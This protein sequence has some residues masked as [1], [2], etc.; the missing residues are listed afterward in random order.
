[1]F[2][3]GVLNKASVARAEP[4]YEYMGNKYN[5]IIHLAGASP[6]G[7]SGGS[8]VN[9]AGQVIGVQSGNMTINSA[10]QGVSMMAPLAA[11]KVLMKARRH[12]NT[13]TLNSGLEE[14]WAQEVGFIR[15]FQGNHGLI[16]RQLK[17]GGA[18]ARAGVEE[19]HVITELDGRPLAFLAD[20]LDAIRKKEP[21]D[22]VLLQV[23]DRVGLNARETEVTLGALEARWRAPKKPHVIVVLT[24]DMGIGDLGVMGN[25]AIR[26]PNIDALAARAAQM[27]NFFVHPVCAPTR[28]CTMT[29]RY[30]YRTRVVDTWRGRAMM[31]PSEKTIAE[32]LRDAGYATGIFGKWHLGDAYPMRAMDQGFDESLVCWG[33]GLA[34]PAEPPENARRY[35]NPLLSHNGETVP[36]EGY[37]T[38]VF[39]DRAIA[40]M[41]RT[42]LSGKSCFTYLPTNAPHGPFH[43]VPD[44]LYRAY[45][46]RGLDD[47][48]ARIYAM[49]ENIDQ[50]MGKLD[51]FLEQ[52]G[53]K[54]DTLLI[55]FHDNGPNGKRYTMNY[56][57]MKT[58]VY[59]GGIRSPLFVEWPGHVKAG[60]T[61]APLAAHIDLFPTILEA[62]DL[63]VPKGLKLDGRSIL[64]ILQGRDVTWPDRVLV[65]QSHRG[66]TPLRHH[67]FALRKGPW[68]LLRASG[69]GK[70]EPPESAPFE[71]YNIA[72]DPA[73]TRNLFKAEAAVASELKK[74]YDHWFDDVSSTRENNYAPP[75][76][77]LGNPA[78][79]ETHL[80]HQ[81]WR[82][83]T[84]SGWGTNGEWLVHIE[85]KR[86][87]DV[88]VVLRE[89]ATQAHILLTIGEDSWEHRVDQSADRIHFKGLSLPKGPASIHSVIR[90]G[91]KEMG[92]ARMVVFQR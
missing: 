33:G 84:G 49:I 21:G 43:D 10:P 59:E 73:E 26:T 23:C 92:P 20:A 25:Q 66:D 62:A 64:P 27:E 28:A 61:F 85:K 31:D 36:S 55:Y 67:H 30:N 24:D 34:Q 13:A 11:I 65:L 77:V 68:K 7:T 75:R 52:T 3:H 81:D 79:T 51:A 40:W 16:V 8:W 48:I 83:I 74:T 86:V 9:E 14:L 2:R 91:E 39:F 82:K 29:G 70:E 46:D 4:Y 22:S 71:L 89:T 53:M 44:K 54:R 63:A 1:M 60:Q 32:V 17:K 50:N 78:Q 18:L 80:T 87:F 47:K 76:I 57:G 37:C 35:T 19:W 5:A 42:E 58:D 41:R 45:L 15:A 69:F 90:V 38:D 6:G 56:R 72:E 12:A 88:D